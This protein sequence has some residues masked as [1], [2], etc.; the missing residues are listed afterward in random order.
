MGSSFTLNAIHSTISA[1]ASSPTTAETDEA[2]SGTVNSVHQHYQGDDKSLV[3]TKTGCANNTDT[4]SSTKGTTSASANSTA[5]KRSSIM[6]NGKVNKGR[7]TVNNKKMAIPSNSS[8]PAATVTIKTEPGLGDALLSSNSFSEKNKIYPLPYGPIGSAVA[9][10][11]QHPPTTNAGQATCGAG[12]KKSKNIRINASNSSATL[13]DAPGNGK[14]SQLTTANSGK[15]RSSNG[16]TVHSS[17]IAVANSVNGA[18]SLVP[19]TRNSRII[20]TDIT[21]EERR[22]L[23]KEGMFLYF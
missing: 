2:A 18:S 16:A 5:V 21:D 14:A 11:G 1:S 13:I 12:N 3:L 23:T 7:Q 8:S 9:Q 20:D 10:R 22:L 6:L 15:C 4:I 17:A 19:G